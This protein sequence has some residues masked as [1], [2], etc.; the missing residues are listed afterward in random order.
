MRANKASERY[1]NPIYFASNLQKRTSEAIANK[2]LYLTESPIWRDCSKKG[3][4]KLVSQRQGKLL[5]A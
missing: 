2:L 1:I 5:V 3:L 4:K